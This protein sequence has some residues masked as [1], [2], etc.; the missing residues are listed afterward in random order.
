MAPRTNN[1]KKTKPKKPRVEA[2]C[3]EGEAFKQRFLFVM[4]RTAARGDHTPDRQFVFMMAGRNH[5]HTTNTLL[6]KWKTEEL[7]GDYPSPEKVCLTD[8]GHKQ[9]AKMVGSHKPFTQEEIN[10]KTRVYLDTAEKEVFD[11]LLDG[12]IHAK[13]EVKGAAGPRCAAMTK[14]SFETKLSGLCTFGVICR[15]SKTTIQINERLVFYFGHNRVAAPADPRA[16]GFAEHL[17]AA[18]VAAPANPQDQGKE[19]ANPIEIGLDEVDDED[20]KMAAV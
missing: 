15:P 17:V 19:L 3:P 4:A 18:P 2:G 9:A 1:K 14:T 5:G 12:A 7:V 13:E 8:L 10:T 6:S 16:A 11:H 20:V